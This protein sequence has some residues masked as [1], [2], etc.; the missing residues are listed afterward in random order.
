MS[1]ILMSTG[2]STEARGAQTVAGD[3]M[4]QD[5]SSPSLNV[6]FWA[7]NALADAVWASPRARLIFGLDPEA[8][9]TGRSILAAV[10]PADRGRLLQAMV[11]SV[12]GADPVDMQLR[13]AKE[14]GE[15]RWIDAHAWIQRDAAGAVRKI[16]GHVIDVTER[17]RADA[18]LRALKQQITHLARIS[19]LGEYSGALVHE[20]Q[21][22]LTAIR[23]NAL[24]VRRLL[25]ANVQ[26]GAEMREIIHDILASENR[27]QELIQR[28]RPLLKRRP[29][30][31]RRVEVGT[32]LRNVAALAGSSLHER[33]IAMTM[34]IHPQARAVRGD[35]IELEQVLLNLLLNASHAMGANAP[36]A[37]HIEIAAAPERDAREIRFSVT[38]AGTGIATEHL[39]CIFDPFFSTKDEGV[40]LG[41]SICR[42][43]VG[44]HQGSLWAVNNPDRGATFHFTVPMM[45]ETGAP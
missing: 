30:Q 38:D 40:G 18:E 19:T 29:P 15:V 16:S 28:M 33:G 31:F 42:A 7:W 45:R 23:C 10:H 41:L 39:E 4:P 5:I 8:A 17:R 25:E 26:D 34:H 9:L 24:A 13:L 12:G 44:S 43:I 20:L 1:S 27:A 14:G 32:I 6:G 21:Q 3:D 11:R 36:S 2:R 22:P 37:R 35:S